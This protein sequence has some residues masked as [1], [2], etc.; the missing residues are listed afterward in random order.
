MSRQMVAAVEGGAIDKQATRP[1]RGRVPIVR[2]LT[3][4]STMI[5]VPGSAK[6]EV[7]VTWLDRVASTVISF[8]STSYKYVA[9]FTIAFI[10]SA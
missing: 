3:T 7:Q 10:S 8:D 6:I 4:M 1:R 9:T 5:N 2:E